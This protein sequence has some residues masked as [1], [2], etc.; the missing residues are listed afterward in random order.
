MGGGVLEGAPGMAVPPGGGG[1]GTSEQLVCGPRVI[2]QF[3]R[4]FPP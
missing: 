4:P 1:S 3:A 2:R